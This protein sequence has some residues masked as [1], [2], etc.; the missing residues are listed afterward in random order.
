MPCAVPGKPDACARALHRVWQERGDVQQRITHAYDPSSEVHTADG[1][2][3]RSRGD[4]PWE[5]RKHPCNRRLRPAGCNSPTRAA[6]CA[7]HPHRRASLRHA[8][9]SDAVAHC[10]RVM[11]ISSERCRCWRFLPLN[12]NGALIRTPH[13]LASTV[14]ITSKRAC[15]FNVSVISNG[16]VL[17]VVQL[18]VMIQRVKRFP[19]LV[20]LFPCAYASHQQMTV[21]VHSEHLCMRTFL[22]KYWHI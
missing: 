14:S 5:D 16:Y 9:S 7:N 15:G 13:Q 19:R 20:S 10:K 11:V 18:T 4:Q 22:M 12:Q 3:Y 17:I 8:L 6:S 2:T 1:S 21:V